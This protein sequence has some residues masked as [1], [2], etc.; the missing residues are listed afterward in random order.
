MGGD[1]Q[2]SK[3]C[4][5]FDHMPYIS[6]VICQAFKAVTMETIWSNIELSDEIKR[7]K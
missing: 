1:D 3:A 5:N 4:E 2:I 6:I 7:D